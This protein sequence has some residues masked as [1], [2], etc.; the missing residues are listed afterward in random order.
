MH[1]YH[2]HSKVLSL[3]SLQ[4][5]GDKAKINEHMPEAFIANLNAEYLNLLEIKHAVDMDQRQGHNCS[6]WVDII[7]D[8][9]AVRNSVNTNHKRETKEA[10]RKSPQGERHWQSRERDI[11]DFRAMFQVMERVLLNAIIVREKVTWQKNVQ[12][13]ND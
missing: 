3:V 11:A 9:L 2:Y 6:T 10:A 7:R 12:I 4:Y 1:T 13:L 5:M 8:G